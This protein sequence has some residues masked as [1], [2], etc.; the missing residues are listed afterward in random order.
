MV[1]TLS[2]PSEATLLHSQVWE[3][4]EQEYWVGDCPLLSRNKASVVKKRV[5]KHSI[6][7][8]SEVPFI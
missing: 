2:D 1:I 3:F 4:P 7:W 8:E 6:E 5:L